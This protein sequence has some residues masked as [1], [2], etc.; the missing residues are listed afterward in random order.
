[1]S[2]AKFV[3][4]YTTQVTMATPRIRGTSGELMEVDVAPTPR[5]VLMSDPRPGGRTKIY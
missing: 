5:P 4:T 1:M 3:T 2:T